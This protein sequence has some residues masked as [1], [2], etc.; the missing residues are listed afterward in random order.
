MIQQSKNGTGSIEAVA[1]AHAMN[2]DLPPVGPTVTVRLLVTPP[3]AEL[4][5]ESFN[6]NNRRFDEALISSLVSEIRRGAWVCTHQGIAFTAGRCLSDGQHRLEALRRCGVPLEMLVTFN[7]PDECRDKVD[8]GKNRSLVNKLELVGD[9]NSKRRFTLVR[10]CIG[11]LFGHL[12]GMPRTV[13]SFRVLERPFCVGVEYVVALGD[14]FRPWTAAPI[15]GAVAFAYRANPETVAMF[16]K[17]VISGEGL[18]SGDPEYALRRGVEVMG[19]NGR[20]GSAARMLLS[21][22]TLAAIAAKIEGRRLV[23]VQEN[24][25][26]ISFFRGQYTAAESSAIS[27]IVGRAS[28]LE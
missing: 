9:S 8:I 16:A 26:S 17:N 15:M 18:Q 20:G 22:K 27:A 12:K 23:K 25:E 3:M 10:Q 21:N 19:P 2:G 4:W 14:G 13:E 1:M 5:L 6:F 24:R 11:L 7:Q 28:T